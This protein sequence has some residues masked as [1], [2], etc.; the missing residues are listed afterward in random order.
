MQKTATPKPR[1]RGSIYSYWFL[2]PAF[3]IFIVFFIVP[4]VISL[5]FSMTVWD[6][7][8][9]RFVG[10]ENFKTFLTTYSMS[11]GIKNTFI[12]AILTSGIKVILAFFIAIFLT[13]KIKSKN[14]LRSIVFFPKLVSAIAIGIAFK[15]LMHPT[16]GLINRVLGT[17]GINSV[18]WLGNR[19]IALY[20]VIVTDV[21]KGL[22]I[23]T[24][25]YI[26]GISSIDS[27]YYEAAEI[28]GATGW[29]K[30][31]HITLPNLR[32]IL[33]YTLITSLIGGLQMFD[34]PQLLV[35]NS[36]PNNATLTASVFIYNQAFS[37][38]YMYNRASAASMIMF[39]IICVLSA[40]VFFLMRDKYEAQI[41]KQLRKQRKEAKRMLKEEGRA[42]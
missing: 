40:I 15:A 34:I 5:Y 22:S 10:L 13:S 25:I 20:S 3:V 41:Q 37:G 35:L 11:I 17:V 24:V 8:S 42:P 18:D 21:W 32:T 12:Y 29:Q 28:D 36:G 4:M 6:F 14:I 38:S 16:N 19:N 23:A 7:N 33:I 1:D 9:S 27:S 39:L 26:A 2:V 31:I 30:F